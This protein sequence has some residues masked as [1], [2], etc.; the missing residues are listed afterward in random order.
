MKQENPYSEHKCSFAT[1]T[2]P[3]VCKISRFMS[4]LEMLGHEDGTVGN[5]YCCDEH[6]S[7]ALVSLMTL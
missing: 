6:S 1:C 3:S 4:K 5:I 7:H 2:L